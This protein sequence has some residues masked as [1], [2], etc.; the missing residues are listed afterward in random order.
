MIITLCGSARFEPWYHMWNEALSLA[1]HCVFGLGSY[2]SLNAGKK[3]WYT[4]AE[5][6]TLDLV[7]MDKIRAS[8]L[9][10]VLNKFAYMGTSTMREYDVAIALRK[11]VAT[12]ES[13]GEGLGIDWK[14]SAEC[15][16]AAAGYGVPVGYGSPRATYRLPE[17][18]WDGGF[19][20]A[21]GAKRTAIVER[22]QA[23]EAVAMLV[24]SEAA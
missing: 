18:I 7:H 3:D 13:W 10:F 5:K 8:D 4:P 16:A 22:L 19:L 23:R 11:H 14:H 9:V 12:L 15:R 17:T 2:P 24:R 1:G 20:G 21:G 6:E